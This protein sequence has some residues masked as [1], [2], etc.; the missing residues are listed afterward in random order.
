MVTVQLSPGV[1]SVAGS[2][3]KVIGPPETAAGWSPEDAQEIENHPPVTLT[4][5]LKVTVRFAFAATPVAPSAGVVEA[6]YGAASPASVGVS[7]K[8]STA[9]PSSAPVALKSFQRIQKEAPG[10]IA[11]PVI[12]W[13]IAVR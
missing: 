10:R 8:S 12:V 13:L 5:S 11:R 6:T 7:E 2:R 9:R 3:V 1:K 4:A